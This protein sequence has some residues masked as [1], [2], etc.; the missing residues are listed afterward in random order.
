MSKQI[1]QPRDAAK[2]RLQ[3]LWRR[4]DVTDSV[5]QFLD[6]HT[7]SS[8]PVLSRSFAAGH[9]RLLCAAGTSKLVKRAIM[10]GLA[11]SG[12]DTKHFRERWGNLERWKETTSAP[13]PTTVALERLPE[14]HLVVLT[15]EMDNNRIVSSVSGEHNRVKSLRFRCRYDNG[16]SLGGGDFELRSVNGGVLC[17][18]YFMPK[19]VGDFDGAPSERTKTLLFM[20]SN[21]PR[22]HPDLSLVL[23]ED[24]E[25][26]QWYDVAMKFDWETS[27]AHLSLDGERVGTQIFSRHP[28]TSVHLYNYAGF[29]SRFGEI[30]IEYYDAASSRPQLHY[31]ELENLERSDSSD[32]ESVSSSD[33]D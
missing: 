10:D 11:N 32:S 26:G 14:K 4:H 22:H 12:R 8:V 5:V 9:L 24:A 21:E 3:S 1:K 19:L 7:I 16:Y 29:K 31:D 13:F 27:E 6:L 15:S 18:T 2:A 25:P 20:G 30:E 23:C 33:S 28:F 17:K